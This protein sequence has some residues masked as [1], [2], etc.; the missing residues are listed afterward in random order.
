MFKRPHSSKTVTPLRSSD[1]RKLREHVT[2]A[3]PACTP[4][5]AKLLLPDGALTCKASTHLDEPVTLYFAPSAASEPDPRLFRLGKGDAGQLVPTC[6]AF[7]LVPSLLPQLETAE[8]V[9]DNLQSGSALFTAGVSHR[10]IHALPDSI[11][12]G[13]LV[14][15]VVYGNPT[16]VVAVGHLGATKRDLLEQDKKGKAVLTLHARGDY[17]WESG[18]KLIAITAGSTPPSSSRPSTPPPPASTSA[19]TNVTDLSTSLA[20]TSIAA[21]LTPSEVDQILHSSILL[22]VQTLAP[23]AY[24]IPASSFYSSHILP[25]RLAT[26]PPQADLKKSSYKKL[27]AL[28]KF[29]HKKGWLVAKEVRGEMVV[30]SGN[31]SNREV[32]TFRRYKTLAQAEASGASSGNSGPS[33]ATTENDKRIQESTGS[34]S[35]TAGVSVNEYLKPSG[36]T[37]KQ[38]L[39]HI[40][41]PRPPHDLY[42]LHSLKTL[43]L[44][45]LSQQSLVHPNSQKHLLLTPEASPTPLA[46]ESLSHQE[47]L[48][49]VLL[50]KG[51]SVG[52]FEGGVMTK[53]EGFKRFI[54]NGTG[55]TEYWSLS[56]VT[57]TGGQEENDQVVKKGKPPIIKVSIKNVGK[58]QVTLVSNHEQ[59]I[60]VIPSL[61]SSDKLAEELKHKSASSVSVQPLAGSAKKNQTPKVE[62]M[63]QGTHDK[64]VTT[65]LVS[66]GIPKKYIEV[67]LSKSKK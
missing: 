38:I 57:A 34:S 8:A 51:E 54:S 59:W 47:L 26:C 13:D 45:Y 25:N 6:Y 15:V 66:K 24:P 3:F 29:A 23:S 21:D 7:D 50:K 1:L 27:T 28:I 60:D 48:T 14:S 18:S 52:E 4:A 20:S 65:L 42:P 62:I 49:S 30:M 40:P 32:E 35:G 43:F 19:P 61:H 9:V 22:T 33:N 16:A 37:V 58:R 12:P 31:T 53:D 56:P 44:S 67:D 36:S 63:C 5:D 41:H 17:L 39:S 64:L 46:L 2:H 10:S 55:F 11:K